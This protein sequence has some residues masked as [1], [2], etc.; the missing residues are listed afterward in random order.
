M[1]PQKLSGCVQI[2]RSDEQAA[3]MERAWFEYTRDQNGLRSATFRMHFRQLGSIRVDQE[4][5]IYQF[6]TEQETI[7]SGLSGPDLPS[8]P[9]LLD[10]YLSILF[11]IE[12]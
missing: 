10:K 11:K 9:R 1:S 7:A 12:S 4:P 3:G 8:L 6:V 5:Q 2:R